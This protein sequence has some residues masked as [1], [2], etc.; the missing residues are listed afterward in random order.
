LALP[1]AGS[2]VAVEAQPGVH[3]LAGQVQ[4]C[5]VVVQD[6]VGAGGQ[7]DLVQLE[8]EPL[9][10]FAGTKFVPLDGGGGKAAEGSG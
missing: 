8:G 10:V 4:D 3:D 2:G 6:E 1:S 9:A 7:D 5:G